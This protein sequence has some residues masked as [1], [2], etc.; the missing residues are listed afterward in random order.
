[1]RLTTVA[2]AAVR[3]EAAWKRRYRATRTG[4]P[5]WSRDDADRLVYLSNASGRFEVHA[6]DRGLDRHRQI[7]DRPEGT[8][9]R[10]PS[11]LDPTGERIWWFA[12]EKGNEHGVWMREPFSGEAAPAVATSLTAAYTAGAAIGS[13]FA[14]VGRASDEEGSVFHVVR[15]SESRE[16]YRHRQS[17]WIGDLSRDETL[18]AMAHS[19]SGDSRNPAVRVVDLTGKTVAEIWDGPGRG[20]EPGRWSP[21]RADRRLLVSHERTG[22]SRPLI[23]GVSADEQREIDLDLAGEVEADWFPDAEALLIR[24]AHR[25]RG[26]LYRYDLAGGRLARLETEPG[27]I[28]AARVRPDGDVWY[29]WTNAATPPEIRSLRGG[30]VMRAPGEPAPTGRPYQ[31]HEA[32]G[33][34]VFV[35][36]PHGARRPHPAIFMIHGGPEAHD[37]DAFSASVQ[38]WVD[39]GFAVVLVNYRGSSGYGKAWRDALVGRPGLTELEDIAKAHELVVGAG[40]VDP[41]RSIL[42]GGSWGGYLTLL[43][44]GVQPERWT[45][46]IGII[47]VGDSVAAYEDEME[48]LKRYDDALFGGAPTDVPEL[49]RRSN[50]LT[51]AERLRVPVLLLVGR[52]DPRCPSRSVDI[53]AARLRELAKPFEEYRYDAAHGSLVIEEQIQ[54]LERQIAFA[55]KHLGTA[56]PI[57]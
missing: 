21:R 30:V 19:E 55:S 11:Q 4:F 56:S 31:D 13:D 23:W 37:Q 50:P 51:Y 40:I 3:T 39:H 32:D 17:A 54:Q 43:G 53:Y 46:G 27:T 49:Y 48:P 47:P 38:A 33:V 14:V 42:S 1:M 36:E 52:N 6:W 10:V 16:I 41:R 44:L 20:L 57:A 45:L 34:H 5:T 25:G 29:Q 26:E 2:A 18:L 24:H 35:A 8:G 22:V 28:T 9:Y 12:D 15:G 7:T